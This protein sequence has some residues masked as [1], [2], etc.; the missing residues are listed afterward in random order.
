MSRRVHPHSALISR[1]ALISD[2]YD[3]LISDYLSPG[4]I[5]QLVVSSGGYVLYIDSPET[6][7]PPTS[8]RLLYF[9][10]LYTQR[11]LVSEG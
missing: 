3:L 8:L 7:Q 2:K 5:S 6:P 4:S 9:T 1:L 10:S 11:E